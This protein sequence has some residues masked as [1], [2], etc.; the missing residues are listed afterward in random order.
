M[1]NI[2]IVLPFFALISVKSETAYAI[3]CADIFRH[4]L[5]SQLSAGDHI[6]LLEAFA[7]LNLPFQPESFY[8]INS[9]DWPTAAASVFNRYNQSV[10]QLANAAF[11]NFRFQFWR[12]Q[13]APANVWANRQNRRAY[14][15]WLG[16]ELGF[17][18]LEDFH[19]LSRENL[20]G[21]FGAGLLVR[22]GSIEA[23]LKDFNQHY[24]W[25]EWKLNKAPDGFY[26]DRSNIHRYYRWLEKELDIKSPEEWKTVTRED[27]EQ[28]Y[29]A[30]IY[31][32]APLI[33]ILRELYPNR[34]WEAWMF[35]VPNGF[36]KNRENVI[37]FV[38]FLGEINGWQ[39]PEDFYGLTKKMIVDNKGGVILR[40]YRVVDLPSLIHPDFPFRPW[41]FSQS[42]KYFWK[43]KENRVEYFE[44]LGNKLGFRE[45]ADWYGLTKEL[46]I[47]NGGTGLFKVFGDSRV[48][49]LREFFPDFDF[50]P[51]LFRGHVNGE[52]ADLSM[53]LKYIDWLEGIAG[54]KSRD[55]WLLGGRD[56]VI[57]NQ[58]AGL[59]ATYYDGSLFKML[60]EL[61]PHYR[62]SKNDLV[63]LQNQNRLVKIVKEMFPGEE[64]LVNYR[65]NY[66]RFNGSGRPIEI[67]VFLPNRKI[68]FE[69]QGEQHYKPVAIFGGERGFR[70]TQRRDAEK[71]ELIRNSDLQVYEIPYTW[72]KTLEYVA[73]VIRSVD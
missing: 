34:R 16:R 58:G 56:L 26:A 33:E 51:W 50:L 47:N 42:P 62:I 61:R 12:F 37:K 43:S 29:G 63:P 4:E 9:R 55:D 54:I 18:T 7:M 35:T 6:Q 64:V 48:N 19:Q 24:E 66:L 21:N 71:R 45:P 5:S 67:D 70:E 25:K 22:M 11:P 2:C 32:R 1:S 53:K 46:L 28:N 8:Q 38:E 13:K 3:R 30:T 41:L 68:G 31:R 27:F 65:P 20:Q 59:L 40:D 10:S 52:W 15:I 60:A 17:K 36:F 57:L 72:D 49:F 44:W 39:R 69:Y 73:E 23:L 14:L